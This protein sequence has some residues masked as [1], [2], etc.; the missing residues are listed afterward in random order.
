MDVIDRVP[1]L[2]SQA[3]ALRQRMVDERVR[4]RAH[5][6]LEGEDAPAVRDWT[7]PS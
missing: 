7:W 1:S 5:T 3:A 6:R 2:G 4:C